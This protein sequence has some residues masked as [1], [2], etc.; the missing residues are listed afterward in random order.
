MTLQRSEWERKWQERWLDYYQILGVH[1][2]A[3]PHLI[4]V[5]FQAQVNRYRPSNKETGDAARFT[6]IKEAYKV[7]SEPIMR[8]WY[9]EL[10]RATEG[11][12]SIG[13]AAEETWAGSGQTSRQDTLGESLR[14]I[15]LPP[16]VW[17]EKIGME[18]CLVPAGEFQMGSLRGRG[19]DD[20]SPQHSVYLDAYY[21]GRY[22]VT[23]AQY[24]RF[25]QETDHQVPFG[26]SSSAK[27][28]NWHQRRKTPPK[29]KEDHPVVLVSWRDA[30]TYCKWAG[31][32]LPTEAEW[33]KA[34]RGLEGQTYPWGDEWN[35]RL[36]NSFEGGEGGTT[37]V[38]MYSPEGDSPYGC[39]DMAG[40]VWEWSSS[41]KKWYPYGANDG[42]EDLDVDGFRVLRGGS[43][44]DWGGGVRC[45]YRSGYNP[46]YGYELI[47]FRAVVEPDFA[48]RLQRL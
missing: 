46:N 43:F 23:N 30:M 24:A 25:V 1:F 41:L 31:L 7:L 34:A 36:C 20:E 27:A 40:N 12:A 4:E 13:R 33:E 16:R 19:K 32:R 42:R 44:E 11:S 22:P 48:Y 26:S 28:Y 15:S 37:P 17:W 10:Y 45:A 9:D 14:A 3:E 21:I 8:A 18:F 38:G 35:A 29:G 2:T 5:A 47:G 39:A 6:A